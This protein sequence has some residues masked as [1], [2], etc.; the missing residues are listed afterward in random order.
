MARAGRL[1]ES[2]TFQRQAAGAGDGMGNVLAAFADITGAT[3]IPADI[4][5]LR[6]GETVLAEGVQGR[7][8]FRVIVRYT[9]TLAA[10]SVNDRM[11]DARDASR[12]F[13]IKAPPVNYDR[14]RQMLDILVEQGGANG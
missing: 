2:V 14:K 9:N 10:I 12:V 5:P 4:T 8:V 11:V 6:H 1:R 3:G 7:R 13:N